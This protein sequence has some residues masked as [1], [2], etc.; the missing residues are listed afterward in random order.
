M[1]YALLIGAVCL[2]AISGKAHAV[3]TL[4]PEQLK[5][6]EE[7]ISQCAKETIEKSGLSVSPSCYIECKLTGWPPRLECKL[8][9]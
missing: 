7:Q 5:Q 3:E 6:I 8:K 2:I 9:C 1:R 4:T